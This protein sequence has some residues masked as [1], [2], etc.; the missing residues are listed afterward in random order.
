MF[1]VDGTLIKT[2]THR[3]TKSQNFITQVVGGTELDYLR[4]ELN[5]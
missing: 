4:L 2:P 1:R 5:L 3:E